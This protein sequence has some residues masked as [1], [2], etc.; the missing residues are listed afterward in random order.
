MITKKNFGLA[1][2]LIVLSF[3]YFFEY[4]NLDGDFLFC[5][6]IL[7]ILLNIS[8][9][10]KMPLLSNLFIFILLVFPHILEKIN[11]LYGLNFNE[12][13]KFLTIFTVGVVLLKH[14]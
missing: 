1:F 2:S 9:R 4:I 5:I 6:E 10:P 8:S 13:G 7:G 11:R 12:Y 14:K 3:L